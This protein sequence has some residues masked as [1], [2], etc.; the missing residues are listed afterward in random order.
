[1]LVGMLMVQRFLR[2]EQSRRLQ[3]ETELL[4]L[5]EKTVRVGHCTF[6]VTSGRMTLSDELKNILGAQDAPMI[7]AATWRRSL[8][9]M[10]DP[11]QADGTGFRLP[12]SGEVIAARIQRPDGTA[13]DVE[14]IGAPDVEDDAGRPRM[15]RMVVRDITEQLEERRKLKLASEETKRLLEE[16]DAVRRVLLNMLEDQREAERSVRMSE[17]RLRLA[18][19]AA[20]QGLYDLNVQTGEAIVSPEYARMLGYDP[21][22][23]HETNQA[24]LERLHPDDRPATE[25]IYRDFLSGRDPEYRVEFRQRTAAGGWK[26][27]LSLGKIVEY[28]A[29]GLPLRMLGTYT[30]ID[31][32]KKIEEALRESEARY[33]SLVD[34]SP[35]AIALIQD[36]IIAFANP[37][38]VQLLNA[39]SAERLIGRSFTEFLSARGRDRAIVN[40]QALL[41]A[42]GPS[43]P[44]RANLRRLDGRFV[45]VEIVGVP[46]M[47]LGRPSL[48]VIAVDI[49][50]R[51]AAEEHLRRSNEQLRT[52]ASRMEHLRDEEHRRMS[53]DLH[54]TLGQELTAVRM[55]LT[56]IARMSNI[57]D[58]RRQ[59]AKTAEVVD[60]TIESTRRIS[61]LLHPAVLD[62]LG[63]AD[64][65]LW[66]SEEFQEHH[67]H[68]CRLSIPEQ[69]PSLPNQ[70][71]LVMYRVAQE[72]LTNIA[73]HAHATDV[74]IAVE[75]E[76]DQLRLQI[77][78]N[79]VGIEHHEVKHPRG[80]LGIFGLRERLRM[81]GG[82]LELKDA[83][84]RG[85]MLIA[86]I[87]LTHTANPA[88][89]A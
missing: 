81:A 20:Q 14:I 79:G 73:K 40:V 47:R 26:W 22:T 65:L 10:P 64:A 12:A 17:E 43:K 8:A 13:R 6:D 59:V 63:F 42:A 76:H 74:I 56:L 35:Y 51:I 32:R 80:G 28:D 83:P 60:R 67:P 61:L 52:L 49:S 31:E 21:A 9:G 41:N 34:S 87:P 71:S 1:M 55:D 78:D 33:R 57:D 82:E 48:Q 11:S 45:P 5:S 15:K 7:E 19:Q 3:A 88:G 37:S 44:I 30:D 18:L 16:S 54:D 62:R 2:F 70:V 23:F 85:T 36:G 89:P 58:V 27:I 50:D 39:D 68:H 75:V 4:K 38:A 29:G 66:L 72:A 84:E 77:Q 86:R 69:L 53:R 24:W 46:V 25:R